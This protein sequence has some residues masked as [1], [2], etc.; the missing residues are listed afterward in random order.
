M[1][2]QKHSKDYVTQIVQMADAGK[3]DAEIAKNLGITKRTLRK[4]AED[5]DNTIGLAF[6]VRDDPE[7][8]FWEAAERAVK[9]LVLYCLSHNGVEETVSYVDSETGTRIST[10]TGKYPPKHILDKF[11]PDTQVNEPE[12]VI[13]LEEATP[14]DG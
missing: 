7:G 11:L 10:T 12:F 2:K 14:N 1:S 9:R 4:W 5:H 3:S 6:R 13:R 8:N